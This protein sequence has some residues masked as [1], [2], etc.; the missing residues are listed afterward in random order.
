[1]DRWSQARR[2]VLARDGDKCLRC[3]GPAVD[4]HHRRPKGMGGTSDKS[5]AFGLANLIS[6]CRECHAWVHE[7]PEQGYLTG[8]LL[9]SW[10][11]P[12]RFPLLLKPGSTYIYL[13]ADGSFERCG[14][15]VL[16]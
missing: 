11:D 7:H 4:V 1:M 3:L 9:H 6:L 10:D 8:Y 16:F 15:I 5:I 14:E 2:L 12:A 13:R